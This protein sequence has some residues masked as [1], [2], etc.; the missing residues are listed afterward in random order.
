ME[1]EGAECAGRGGGH[2]PLHQIPPECH[3]GAPGKR[4]QIEADPNNRSSL[5]VS[6]VRGR[7]SRAGQVLPE[8]EFGV[9]P[10]PKRLPPMWIRLAHHPLLKSPRKTVLDL[11]QKC[12]WFSETLTSGASGHAQ[13]AF[14][15]SWGATPPPNRSGGSGCRIQRSRFPNQEPEKEV[16]HSRLF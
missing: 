9:T 7:G 15:A 3:S 14:A 6:V 4:V 12:G 5:G 1:K 2:S 16:Q 8:T 10:S 11:L 13:S